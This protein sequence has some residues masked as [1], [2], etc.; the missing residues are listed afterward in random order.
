M[1]GLLFGILYLGE[2]LKCAITITHTLPSTYVSFRENSLESE[3]CNIFFTSF[4][5]TIRDK[6]QQRQN[7][8]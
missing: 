3:F 4:A 5:G 6:S 7:K 2:N 1:V 8:K